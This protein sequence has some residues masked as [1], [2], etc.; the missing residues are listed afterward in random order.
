MKKENLIEH[1]QNNTYEEIALLLQGGG[2]LGSYQAGVCE[3]LTENN[4]EPTWIAGISIGALNTAIIAG[5][6]PET[7]IQQLK[8]FWNTI[9]P[10]NIAHNNFINEWMQNL[11]D[12]SRK[13]LNKME[14]NK[15]ILTGQKGFFSPR[16]LPVFPFAPIKNQ[17]DKLSYYDTSKLKETLLK[18]ADFDLINKGKIRVSLGVV[19]VRTGEFSYFDNTKEVLKPEH[20]M[21]SGALPPSFPA[22][23][24]DGEYYWDGGLVSNMPI[25]EIIENNQFKDTLVFQVDLWQAEG[26][27]PETFEDISHRT[28]DI[29]FASRSKLVSDTLA[30]QQSNALMLKELLLHI[31]EEV[32]QNNLWCQR[33]QIMAKESKLKVI[34]LIYKNKNYEGAAKAYEFSS[35]TMNEHWKSGMNDINEALLQDYN[36]INNSTKI[37]HFK[38]KF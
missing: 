27:L 11:P 32:K 9:C 5:N 33:A 15:T 37:N 13:I 26:K 38:P 12:Q 14:A 22:V 4:I 19:N 7:R 17:L 3:V 28:K 30:E 21:A 31:P 10:S 23:E 29:Q 8:N 2:A 18:F 36:D 24:I 20:F 6:P 16:F 35:L 34:H 1:I 25:T